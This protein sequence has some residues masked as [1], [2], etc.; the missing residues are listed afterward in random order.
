MGR[1]KVS[2]LL[3]LVVLVLS[4]FPCAYVFA[5]WQENGNAICTASPHTSGQ[6]ITTSDGSGGAIITWTD[7]RS[8]NSDIYA[9]RVDALGNVLWTAGGMAVCAADST[10]FQPRIASD[11]LG[12]AIITWLDKRSG[13]YD[14]YAQRVNASGSPLWPAGGVAVCTAD[15]S[16]NYLRI[17]SDGSGGA[18]IAWEDNR[19]GNYDVYAQRVS[20]L[21]SML[22]TS[23]GALVSAR[24]SGKIW[25]SILSDGSG[26]VI[27][28]WCDY[29]TPGGYDIYAQRVDASGNRTW[30]TN[31]VAI[32][33][34]P[35]GQGHPE[36]T[37]DGASGA[38]IAWSDYRT[39][40]FGDIYAQR[41]DGSGNVKW[42]TDGVAV[43]EMETAS[44]AYQITSDGASGALITWHDDRSGGENYDIYAQRVDG[45]GNLLWSDGAVVCSANSG[46]MYPVIVSDG[47][48]GAIITWVDYRSGTSWDIYAQKVDSS[49]T[50]VWAANGVGICT[51]DSDQYGPWPTWDGAGGAVI[52]WSDERNGKVDVY[53]QH[54]DSRAC[55]FVLW[56][57]DGYSVCSLAE[58][59]W[60]Q[61]ICSDGSGGA[62][63]LWEDQRSGNDDLY[64]QRMDALGCAL[65]TA[66]GV[67][68]CTADS[69]QWSPQITSDGSGGA[70]ATWEDRRRGQWDIYAQRVDA[71]GGVMWADTCVSIC[72]LVG[73]QTAPQIILDGSGGAIIT[74]QDYR[75]GVGWDIYA[76]RV[77]TDAQWKWT[78][79]GVA[80]CTAAGGQ[81]NP[82]IT[83]D[84]AGGAIITWQDYRNSSNYDIYAQRVDALGN[85]LWTVGGLVVCTADFNQTY[86]Q[87]TSDGAGGAII[88]WQD[89]RSA[90]W[91]IYT[92]RVDALGNVKWG[93]NGVAM[94]TLA[95]DQW[96]QKIGSDGAG[97]A[98]IVWEDYRAGNCDLYAQRV[99]ALGNV[100]WT[101]SGV[102]VS[103]AAGD[104][105]NPKLTSDGSGGAIMTWQDNRMGIYP[106]IYAQR[107][108]A[109]GSM[110]WAVNGVAVCAADSNQS[111]PEL[112]SD[113][114]GG[115]IITWEDHRNGDS[116]DVYA[117][118]ITVTGTIDVP[119]TPAAVKVVTGLSQNAPNPFNPLTRI[120]FSV[121]VPSEVSLRI[122]DIAGRMLRTLEQGWREAGVYSEV[123]DGRGDDGV[124]LPSGVYFYSLKAGDF[125]AAHKMVL[126]K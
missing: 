27:I 106:D 73:D 69:N 103:T 41:V 122:Y 91:D 34:A 40:P 76:Q 101:A 96:Y 29:L 99:D 12:G 18:I 92:Q 110:S 71:S 30:T 36:I 86:P 3:L 118:R 52:A 75:S 121:A 55:E 50:M 102:A 20:V 89:H 80:I 33:T 13:N 15:S 45:L 47:S 116:Y 88:T 107:V 98:I 95:G 70:I 57:E 87:I 8:G 68:I 72:E 82:Q 94:C 63:I 85:V 19:N 38:I 126:L 24:Q 66:N 125:A 65:W 51:A 104:Q 120:T 79:S 53:A 48:G 43:S 84:G 124:V 90:S 11:N 25:P 6:A 112:T 22:W 61:R 42:M 49:G 21:G 83:P 97:G 105:L 2:K 39:N 46:Q 17:V 9:Q 111:Y 35:R 23:N 44:E 117:E 81:L 64:A 123:W 58:D 16:Q 56:Q 7:K 37:S 59:Q 1:V 32:C 78:N 114:F 60:F 31:G 74:W 4:M 93:A 14:V 113:G 100:K 67:S 5:S 119:F 77:D 10:Q 28:A 108:D 109:L 115:A 26:G 62:I 54:I